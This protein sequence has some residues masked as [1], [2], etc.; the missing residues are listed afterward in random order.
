MVGS[1]DAAPIRSCE[2]LERVDFSDGSK[3]PDKQSDVDSTQ[4]YKGL[5][6]ATDVKKT[7]VRDSLLMLCYVIHISYL[8][9]H[10]GNKQL[11]KLGYI[12][13]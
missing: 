11:K 8:S 1:Q 5:P 6:M 12:F 10:R 2:I 9:F 7:K 3:E 13:I 4:C